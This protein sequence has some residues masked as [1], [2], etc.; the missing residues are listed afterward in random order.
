MWPIS[1]GVL[2]DQD[3]GIVIE[4]TGDGFFAAGEAGFT[5][6]ENPL[7]RLDLDQ[8]LVP[9]AHPDRVSLYGSYLHRSALVHPPGAILHGAEAMSSIGSMRLRQAGQAR[10][11]V[12]GRVSLVV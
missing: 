12:I 1:N 8:Q 10:D 7:V 9:D 3:L 5:P 6:S 4:G 2:A 11:G